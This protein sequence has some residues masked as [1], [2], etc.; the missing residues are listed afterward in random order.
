[1]EQLVQRL[2]HLNR[3]VALAAGLA[4]LA[5]VLLT[6][7][8]IVLRRLGASLGGTEE[9]SGYTMAATTSWSLAY[10]LTELAHVR[11]DLVRIKCGAFGRALLDAVALSVLTATAIFVAIQGWNVLGRSIELGSRAN[12]P[13]ETPLWIPQALWWSGWVWFAIS[14]S[15]MMT[16]VVWLAVQRRWAEIDRMAGTTDTP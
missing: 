9:L 13:L 3:K 1:M 12:T 16:A 14:A 7:T 4:L 10:A 2:R 11:I 8:D 6:L 5:C 15:L